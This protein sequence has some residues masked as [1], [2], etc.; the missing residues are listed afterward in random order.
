V[1]RSKLSV[2]LAGAME[3]ANKLGAG[4]RKDLTPFLESLDLTVLNPCEFEPHQLKGL[5][6][7]RLPEYY[8]DFEGNQVKPKYWHELKN[9][10]ER[11]LYNRFLK[12]MRRIIHY[13]MRLVA[14][15]DYVVVLWDEATSKGAGTHAELTEAF[16][17]NIPV[18]C[19]ALTDI[20]AWCKACCTE[21]F[22]DFESLKEFLKEEFDAQLS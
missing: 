8:T 9:A 3:N 12:Y 6:P 13:D 7:N 19:V 16:L 10:K 22:L 20:P 18:Y 21:I 2:Y 17:N 15:V 4:W 1:V 5:Q 14:K 11:H